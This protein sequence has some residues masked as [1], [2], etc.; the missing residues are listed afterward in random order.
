VMARAAAAGLTPVMSG[1][2]GANGRY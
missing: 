1:D 2:V